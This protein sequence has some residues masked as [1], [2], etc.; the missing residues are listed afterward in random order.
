ME[1]LQVKFVVT[2]KYVYMGITEATDNI[3]SIFSN[4]TGVTTVRSIITDNFLNKELQKYILRNSLYLRLISKSADPYPELSLETTADDIIRIVLKVPTRDSMYR[5]GF[6]KVDFILS[7]LIIKGIFNAAL[8]DKMDQ[9]QVKDLVALILSQ[10]NLCDKE[11]GMYPNVSMGFSVI[12]S[13]FEYD[14]GV[15]P[16][17]F[18]SNE[19]Q[20]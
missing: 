17:E 15:L 1:E 4:K 5:N 18:P 14:D 11:I 6:K 20:L 9:T 8:Y 13:N 2:N 10:F 19:Y 3:A 12:I 16:E 7:N